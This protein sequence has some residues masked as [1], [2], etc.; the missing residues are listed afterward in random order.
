MPRACRVCEG[1]PDSDVATGEQLRERPQRGLSK[2]R[3]DGGAEGRRDRGRNTGWEQRDGGW[4]D[5]VLPFYSYTRDELR[6]PQAACPHPV[7]LSQACCLAQ[8]SISQD[9]HSPGQSCT[10]PRRLPPFLS[11]A[12][13]SRHTKTPDVRP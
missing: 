7:L 13:S 12:A 3:K 2:G 4:R 6:A 10:T 1:R 8:P 9:T 5:G 11:S